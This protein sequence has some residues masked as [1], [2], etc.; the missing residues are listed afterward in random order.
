MPHGRNEFCVFN[1]IINQPP[2]ASAIIGCSS[3]TFSLIVLIPK[4][5][6]TNQAAEKKGVDENSKA[7]AI[8]LRL[9]NK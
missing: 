7:H 2:F 9:K 3:A 4:L 5:I 1:I 6:V 8:T